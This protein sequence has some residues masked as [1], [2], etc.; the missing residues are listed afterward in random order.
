MKGLANFL[1][2]ASRCV[3]TNEAGA[4]QMYGTCENIGESAIGMVRESWVGES[5]H[6]LIYI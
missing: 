4:S 3:Q 2:V 5:K 1:F 6:S